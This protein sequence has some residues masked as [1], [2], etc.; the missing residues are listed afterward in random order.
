[1]KH[2]LSRTWFIGVLAALCMPAQAALNVLS[3][4]AEWAALASEIGGKR[5]NVSSATTGQQDPHR[6]EA[7]P[8]LIARVRN[9]DLLVC[10][11]LD[12]EAGWLPV[13]LQ[14]SGNRRIQPGQPGN[15]VAGNLVPRLELPTQ[16]D[17]AQGDVHGSGNPHIQLNPHNLVPVGEALATRLGELDPANAEAYRA[18]YAD[19]RARLEFAMQR[20]EQQAVA[21]NGVGVIAHH[22]D[23][24]YLFD[25]LGMREIGNLEPKPGLEPSSAHLAALLQQLRQDPARMVLHTPYQSERASQWLSAQAS[26]PAVMIPN[27]VGGTDAAT[28]LFTLFEDIISRLLG[29]LQ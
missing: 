7:R 23:M 25:W 12:L 5:L 1:M 18:A 15:F 3:C 8:S 11:G 17:R 22:K 2:L 28:D 14:Q 19:F 26:I 29:G 9:A 6:I 16:L 21:L 13:L 4:E 27:T 24:V 10:T 20:W